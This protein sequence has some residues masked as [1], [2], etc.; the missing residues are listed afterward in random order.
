MEGAPNG[1]Q[2]VGVGVEGRGVRRDYGYV[3]GYKIAAGGS[4]RRFTHE[5]VAHGRSPVGEDERDAEHDRAAEKEDQ[6]GR[7]SQRRVGPTRLGGHPGR[8][9]G[10]VGDRC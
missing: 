6:P 1:K 10:G 2:G 5:T 9:R 4:K 7:E 3:G 8:L